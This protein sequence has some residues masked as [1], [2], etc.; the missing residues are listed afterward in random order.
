MAKKVKVEEKKGI[1]FEEFFNA[2][3]E[4]EKESKIDKQIVF[5]SLADGIKSAYKKEFGETGQFIV[6]PV[7]AEKKFYVF[8]KKEVVSMD[9]FAKDS[10]EDFDNKLTLEEAQKIDPS[11]QIGDFVL[12]DVTPN[13]FSRIAAQTAKNVIVQAINNK[14]KELVLSEMSNKTG[15]IVKAK[16]RRKEGD[17]VFVEIV[18]TQLEGILMKQDQIPG[19]TYEINSYINV[20]VK[21]IKET[22]KGNTQVIVSRSCTGYIRKLIE[23]EVPEV[24]TKLIDIVNIVREAGERTKIAVKTSY[25]NLDPVGTI[26]GPKGMRISNVQSEVGG[27]ERIDVIEYIDDPLEYIPRALTP[28][29]IL[30]VGIKEDEKVAKVIVPDEK[31]SLAI[32]RRGQNAKLAAKLTGWKIDVKPASQQGEDE[33]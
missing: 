22:L 20:F 2:I 8:R 19:E 29:T 16:I 10:I 12:E 32:G 7:E 14:K 4:L 23:M 26:I 28:A 18:N 33:D 5:D 9:D 25:P 31:L 24:K 27:N 11:Y 21:R 15:E 6:T 17:S 1:D 13:D 30:W 3:E